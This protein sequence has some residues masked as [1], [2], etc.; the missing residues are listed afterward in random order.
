[1]TKKKR[2]KN[3]KNKKMITRI[4]QVQSK[5]TKIGKVEQKVKE[6]EKKEKINK[7][8]LDKNLII[9]K[10]L[11]LFSIIVATILIVLTTLFILFKI[12]PVSTTSMLF[13][14]KP[15]IKTGT[16]T[17]SFGQFIRDNKATVNGSEFREQQLI[18]MLIDK[19]IKWIDVT[20]D[21]IDKEYDKFIKA[22]GGDEA[23]VISTIEKSGFTKDDLIKQLT[24]NVKIS[25]IL[26]Q[27]VS[28]S[29]ERL[30][31]YYNTQTIGV[32]DAVPFE[33]LP[34]AELE[35]W[36]NELKLTLA[37]DEYQNWTKE[38]L[39]NANSKWEVTYFDIN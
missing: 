18:L 39:N 32:T 12:L 2:N 7:N 37:N 10:P 34:E 33:E 26:L 9:M 3:K 14:M 27:R 24:K 25:K 6:S 36:R 19:E 4:Q 22:Y 35:K 8:H 11:H 38:L 13:D 28:V 23:T 31:E 30:K 1:M 16:E 20:Q 15:V 29:D 5:G 17:Y 21:E